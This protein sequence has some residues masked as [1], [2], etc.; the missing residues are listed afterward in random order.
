M[1]IIMKTRSLCSNRYDKWCL[2]HKNY[3]VCLVD[4]APLTLKNTKMTSELLLT[5]CEAASRDQN[6]NQYDTCSILTSLMCISFLKL[7]KL[8][9]GN[10]IASTPRMFHQ[11][12]SCSSSWKTLLDVDSPLHKQEVRSS[13]HKK[14][15]A[16][17]HVIQ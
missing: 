8:P 3:A 12:E 2:I 14:S 9:A 13:L 17:V 5:G 4:W 11:L 16:A 10:N 1:T 15:N 7:L 6:M